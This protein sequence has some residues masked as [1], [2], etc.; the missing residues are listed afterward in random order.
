MSVWHSSSHISPSS[1]KCA[2]HFSI[3]LRRWKNSKGMKN[4]FNTNWR[5]KQWHSFWFWKVWQILLQDS[6]AILVQCIANSIKQSE[7]EKFGS[8]QTNWGSHYKFGWLLQYSVYHVY[9]HF[10]ILRKRRSGMTVQV[11]IFII[12]IEV[13]NG[14]FSQNAMY[15]D[16]ATE[17]IL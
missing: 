9:F 16:A 11:I 13:P 1:V 3:F 4:K 10:F 17:G 6:G 8:I 12:Q 2:K 5:K 7:N 14:I 15:S